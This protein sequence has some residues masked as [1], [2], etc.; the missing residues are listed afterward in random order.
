MLQRKAFWRC[1]EWAVAGCP[2]AA[3]Q[4]AALLAA[5]DLS[6]GPLCS[7][8][9]LHDA[10]FYSCRVQEQTAG[11]HLLRICMLIWR[12]HSIRCHCQSYLHREL[13][14]F[15]ACRTLIIR[16]RLILGGSAHDCSEKGGALFKGSDALETPRGIPANTEDAAAAL[17]SG[18]TRPVACFTWT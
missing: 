6:Q 15:A 4:G 14:N 17:A 3:C 16:K 8:S 9:H 10:L 13:R 11:A 12:V 7:S 5:G 2:A 1:Q 18:C